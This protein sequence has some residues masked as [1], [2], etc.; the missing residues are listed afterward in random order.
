MMRDM[1]TSKGGRLLVRFAK[2]P[3]RAMKRIFKA[4]KIPYVTF[5]GAETYPTHGNHWTPKG[6]AFV[7]ERMKQI[8]QRE[9]DRRAVT[10]VAGPWAANGAFCAPFSCRSRS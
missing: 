1:V 5:D 3:T 8:S 2:D 4:E 10:S 7:A 9:R 6:N